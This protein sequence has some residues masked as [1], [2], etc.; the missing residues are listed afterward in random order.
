MLS[1]EFCR[2]V[3]ARSSFCVDMSI[4]TEARALNLTNQIAGR[5]NRTL[6]VAIIQV[7]FCCLKGIV[8]AMVAHQMSYFD[9]FDRKFGR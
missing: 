2:R 5:N 7:N 9:I 4:G 1:K 3:F 6:K 8:A